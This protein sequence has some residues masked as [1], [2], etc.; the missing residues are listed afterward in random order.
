MS[1]SADE[2]MLVIID[3]SVGYASESNIMVPIALGCH[4]PIVL[5]DDFILE[6]E[7]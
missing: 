4:R 7:V 2:H 1:W 5:L 6:I 3:V